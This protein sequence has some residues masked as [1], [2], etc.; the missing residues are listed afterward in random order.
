MYG[1]IFE[2]IYKGSLMTDGGFMAV[3]T[4]IT[5]IVN[6]D[7]DGV[8]DMS[9]KALGKLMGLP[10]DV[11]VWEDYKVALDILES[12]DKYSNL[13]SEN[14][15]RIIPMSI[16]TDGENNRGW[17]IVNHEYYKKLGGKHDQKEKTRE[18]VRRFRERQKV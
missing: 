18:R 13:P 16:L 12:E 6:C 2:S 3:Y 4:F 17:W 8:V 9:E 1:K 14:G 5:M 10:D 11:I 7:K 15:R